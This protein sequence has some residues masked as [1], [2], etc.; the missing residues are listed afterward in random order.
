MVFNNKSRT[1]NI[2]K[3]TTITQIC[4]ILN[5]VMGFVYRTVFLMFLSNAYLGIN[6][7]FTNILQILSLADLGIGTAIAYRFYKP[8][9]N[10]DIKKVAALM[11]YFK[12]VYRIILFIITILGLLLIPFLK[13]FIKDSSEI[14][15]D[16][17]IV[18]IYLLFLIQTASSYMYAYKQTLLT[19]DQRQ[20]L[21]AIFQSGINLLKNISQIVILVV[22]KNFT[23]TLAVGIVMNIVGNY[24]IGLYVDYRYKDV[25]SIKEKLSIKERNEILKDTRACMC[26][27]I[28]G[29]V[30]SSTDSIILSKFV[31]IISV[32]IYSN[33]LLVITSIKSLACQLFSNSIASLGNMS[34]SVDKERRYDVFKNMNFINLW[35]ASSLSICIFILITPF[36]MLWIGENSTLSKFTVIFLVAQFYLE[37]TRQTNMAFTN[38][39]GLFIKDVYRPFIEATLNLIISIIFTKFLGIA[40]VFLGTVI[41]SCITVIWREPYLLFK[42]YFNRSSKDYWYTYISFTMVTIGMCFLFNFIISYKINSFI[43]WV[44]TGM[45]VFSLT[46][47]TLFLVFKNKKEFIYL[48]STISILYTKIKNRGEAI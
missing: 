15:A 42:Y 28:G 7:L 24:L 25:F 20:H 27:K 2:I 23:Y 6:G 34:V 10:G 1:D 22:M 11:D 14:P 17:N 9:S 32:G 39:S 47:L 41:S 18:V 35:L 12:L 43:S 19:V 16:I 31:G 48:K 46:E 33:Y 5:Q 21:L 37:L 45:I 38:A 8:I 36:I 40:G 26:H 30:L 4:T 13:F 44:V 29:R 3:I